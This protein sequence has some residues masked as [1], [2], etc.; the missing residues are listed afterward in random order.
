M[1]SKTE[2]PH[3]SMPLKDSL[4]GLE[5]SFN[6]LIQQKVATDHSDV[7]DFDESKNFMSQLSLQLDSL[8]RDESFDLARER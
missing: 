8:R 3:M 6:A 7:T 1:D 2:L 4:V 5:S